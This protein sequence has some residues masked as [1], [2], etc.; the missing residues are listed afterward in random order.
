MPACS[1]RD[2]SRHSLIVFS[3]FVLFFCSFSLLS[4][5]SFCTDEC[6]NHAQNLQISFTSVT[7]VLRC[8]GPTKCQFARSAHDYISLLQSY[9]LM[10]LI[11]RFRIC[12]TANG[13][14]P[15]QFDNFWGK[16]CAK[17]FFLDKTGLILLIWG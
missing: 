3:Y 9:N 17:Y 5:N 10:Y 1:S 13:W 15:I 7:V 11:E 2:C 4:S 6:N 16:N 8:S 12:F 14:R